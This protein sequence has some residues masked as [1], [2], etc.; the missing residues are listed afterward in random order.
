M[1]K[2][3]VLQVFTVLNRGGAETNIMNYYRNMDRE[4]FHFDF[5]VHRPEEG[6]YEEEIQSL[7]S[8]VFRLP[9][10]SPLH[11]KDYRRAVR[12]FFDENPGYDIIHGQLSELGVFI[13]EEAARRGVPVIIAHAHNAPHFSDYDAKFLVRELWKRRMRKSVNAHF[14]CG[15]EAAD[16]LF[17]ARRAKDAFT[18][19]NAIAAEDFK[20]DADSGLAVRRELHAEKTLNVINVGRFNKQKN[21]SFLIEIF[22]EALKLNPHMHLFLVGTGELQ[23]DIAGKV[24]ALQMSDKVTFMGSRSDVNRLLHGMDVFLFPS[25]YEGL[26]VSLVEAQASG[27]KCLISDG[28]PRESVLVQENVEVLSLRRNA[29]AWAQRLL[30]LNVSSR[31]DVSD[32][33]RSKGYDIHANAKKLESKYRALLQTAL[34]RPH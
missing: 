19:T 30:A 18:M 8:R 22:S 9:P 1:K 33:I 24:K 10:I 13:Y 17:G 5:L 34:Q 2:I 29:Q 20:Y 12:D 28:I 31:K 14:T 23:E 16:W 7:G 21:H 25:F 11:L 27:I 15:K 32:I 6:A 4:Q 26:P 3:K